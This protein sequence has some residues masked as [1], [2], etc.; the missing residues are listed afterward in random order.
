MA[1]ARRPSRRS[2]GAR[3]T[4]TTSRPSCAASGARGGPA[5][6]PRPP[7]ARA[8]AVRAL[9]RGQIH[10]YNRPAILRGERRMLR[11]VNVPLATGAVAGFAIDIQDL[12]DARFELAR[13]I[14][15]QRELSDRMTAGA[16][17]FDPDRTLNFF[18]HPFAVMAQLDPEW[19]AER[20]EF[21]RVLERMRE[22][23]RLPETR[24]FPAWKDERR[25]WFSSADEVV[26]EEWMLANGDHL[27]IVAQP[28]P[29]G[30]RRPVPLR[31]RE[32]EGAPP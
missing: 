20:P 22:N 19:L 30:G 21:D 6:C 8:A 29:D 18:N 17:Q 13:H 14:E 15:S 3:S 12:E 5:S 27:R 32:A 11:V 31:P 9:E 1:P 25:G 26:E 2:S 23:H 16:A 4:R 7:A 28:L 24:D 10:S